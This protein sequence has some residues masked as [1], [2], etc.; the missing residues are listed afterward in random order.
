MNL[1]DIDPHWPC[2]DGIARFT[3]AVRPGNTWPAMSLEQFAVL[4]GSHLRTAQGAATRWRL[5][6]SRQANEYRVNEA[7]YLGAAYLRM[8]AESYWHDEIDF[9]LDHR[10]DI[11]RRPVSVDLWLQ[12]PDEFCLHQDL[13]REVEIAP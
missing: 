1:Y 10:T 11:K 6:V 13:L 7:T 5:N 9:V 12:P 4:A 3:R 8:P 2:D